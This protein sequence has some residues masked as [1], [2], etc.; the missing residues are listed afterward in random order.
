MILS[1]P[2]ALLRISR[3]R[4][5][6]WPASGYILFFRGT[7]LLVQL[8][9]I[10]YGLAQ[11]QT[12]RESFM[13]PILREP[14]WCAII[15]LSLNTTAYTAEIFRGA[16]QSVPWGQIEAG[17]SLGMSRLLLFR[18]IIVPKAI[19]FALPGYTNEVILLLKGS[20]LASTVTIMELTGV[21]RNIIART[22]K[23]IELFLV[24][25]CIY[26]LLTFIITRL[27]MIVEYRLTAQRRPVKESKQTLEEQM[28]SRE[29]A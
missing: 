28:L 29:T 21:T 23:P 14:H 12:I 19:V 7:P 2:L 27:F 20:A 22:F 3:N 9:I 16:I 1:I 6:A 10:Y 25:G 11:F 18:R 15:A 24:A 26:L 13:W 17:L 4:W 8:F 5:A